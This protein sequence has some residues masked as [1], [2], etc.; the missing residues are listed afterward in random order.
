MSPD[1]ISIWWLVFFASFSV[2]LCVSAMCSLAESVLLSLSMAQIV[3]ISK[4]NRKVGMI[5]EKFKSDPDEPITT[6]LAINTTAH[7]VGAAVAG[8]SFSKI[9]DDSWIWLFSLI[10]TYLMLQFTEILPKTFGVRHNQRLAAWVARP[11]Y[12]T[13]MIGAPINKLLRAVNKPFEGKIGKEEKLTTI[14]EITLLTSLAKS[15]S[16]LNAEQESIINAALKLSTT[17]AET[18]MVPINEVSFLS[19]D[20]SVAEAVQTAKNDSHTRFPVKRHSNGNSVVGYINFKELITG[21]TRLA[22][23]SISED[24]IKGSESL[25][26]LDAYVHDIMYIE[27]T[28][29]VA[30][31]LSKL[32][33]NH[34]HIAMVLGGNNK[35]I[36]GILTLEDLVEELIGEI[37]DEFDCLPE[38]LRRVVATSDS[39]EIDSSILSKDDMLRVG[40]G[41][42][43]GKLCTELKE[44]FQDNSKS[45]VNELAGLD[46]DLRVADWLKSKY[47]SNIK[48]NQYIIC[49]DLKFWIKR[50][51][52]GRIFDL[53]VMK[54]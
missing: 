31:I 13:S 22:D 35:E 39:P 5:W 25:R 50:V 51:R 23:D 38:T 3:D 8:A 11:L 2:A 10:F 49:G 54:K 42:R 16:L 48:R 4:K 19:E 12:W 29:K 44:F 53:L 37:E 28:D 27:K 47:P 18:V 41:L 30:D 21:N 43:V 46:K 34:D 36:V 32:V 26:L 15:H 20:M 6:I 33:K 40:G 14:K 17:T 24:P 9:F 7:T 1:A 52:R 45:C